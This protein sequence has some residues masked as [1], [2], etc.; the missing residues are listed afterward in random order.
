MESGG[1]SRAQ[2]S[3]PLVPV[4]IQMSP[5]RILPPYFS[6]SKSHSR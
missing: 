1:S 2:K 5:V 6:T 3:P 4:P